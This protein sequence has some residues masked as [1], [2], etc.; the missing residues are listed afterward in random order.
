MGSNVFIVDTF[1]KKY[2]CKIGHF[3]IMKHV[4]M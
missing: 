2:T 1:C 3:E 4:Y